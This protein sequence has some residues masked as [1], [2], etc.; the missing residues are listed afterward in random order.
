MLELMIAIRKSESHAGRSLSD[1]VLTVAPLCGHLNLRTVTLCGGSL[2][3]DI[4]TIYTNYIS[5]SWLR[6]LGQKSLLG[7]FV[8]SAM[9]S[10]R[11][12]VVAFTTARVIAKDLE[13][14][15]SECQR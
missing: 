13:N 8:T 7:R 12:D 4:G 9:P 15:W 10:N 5:N 11:F 3:L 14:D 6:Q 2:L 1:F